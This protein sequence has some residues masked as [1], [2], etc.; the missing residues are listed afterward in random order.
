[1][2]EQRG[3]KTDSLLPRYKKQ[4]IFSLDRSARRKELVKKRGKSLRRPK[5]KGENFFSGGARRG[6]RP[7]T[8]A[9]NLR[10]TAESEL[11]L[12]GPSLLMFG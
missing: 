8:S 6:H 4:H 10:I 3:K 12:L 11:A 9:G 5:I 1:M 7:A 2:A